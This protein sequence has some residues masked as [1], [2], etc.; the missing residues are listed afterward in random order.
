MK[1]TRDLLK[2]VFTSMPSTFAYR[3]VKFH[4]YQ[5]LQKLESLEKREA[6]RH[7]QEEEMRIKEEKKKAQPW[8]PPIYQNPLQVQQTIDILDKMIESEK[9]IIEGIQAKKIK[10]QMPKEDN[11]NDGQSQT[12]YG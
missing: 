3:E 5:A 9:K 4:V 10:K 1:S 2:E 6:V 7:S 12:F 11:D 8:Q